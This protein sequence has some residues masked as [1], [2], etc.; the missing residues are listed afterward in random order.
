MRSSSEANIKDMMEKYLTKKKVMVIEDKRPPPSPQS[1][2]SR[3]A[4][5]NNEMWERAVEKDRDERMLMVAK[6][7][8]MLVEQ[9]ITLEKFGAQVKEEAMMTIPQSNDWILKNQDRVEEILAEKFTEKM[10]AFNKFKRE[11]SCL[12]DDFEMISC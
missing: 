1:N 8:S 5:N 4:I 6:K 2:Y 3:S 10:Q 12:Y 7:I 11:F 9:D